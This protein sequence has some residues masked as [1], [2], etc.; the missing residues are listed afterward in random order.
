MSTLLISDV[1]F[2][3]V[4][5]SIFFN[6]ESNINDYMERYKPWV[7]TK[8]QVEKLRNANII[9]FNMAYGRDEKNESFDFDGFKGSY[10][11]NCQTLKALELIK[12][13]IDLTDKEFD[14]RFIDGLIDTFRT[15]II[16]GLEDYKKAKI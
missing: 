16:E 7:N 9:S 6:Y 12:Y 1:V 8:K 10:D 11:N 2:A 13:N 4:L 15:A 5:N 14:F 3:K